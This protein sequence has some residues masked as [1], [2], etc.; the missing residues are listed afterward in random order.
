[1]SERDKSDTVQL[2]KIRMKEELRAKLERDAVARG[3]SLNTAIVD[4]LERSF[5]L[6]KLLGPDVLRIAAAFELSGQQAAQFEG[7]APDEWRTN[8]IC[9]ETAVLT[10]TKDLWRQHPARDK[11]QYSWREW[12]GRLTGYLA[13]LYAPAVVTRADL[14]PPMS[15]G[16]YEAG[17]R[18]REH[19]R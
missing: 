10:L 6:D 16:E 1:M 19:V 13:G 5:A 12:C 3:G 15:D 2:S 9:Y 18:D 8:P 4:R 7:I 14:T 11:V 17:K